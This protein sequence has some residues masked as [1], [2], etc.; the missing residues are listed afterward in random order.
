MISFS[1]SDSVPLGEISSSG[2][3]VG[4]RCRGG[5]GEN[6]SG[7]VGEIQYLYSGIGLRSSIARFDRLRRVSPSFSHSHCHSSLTESLNFWSVFV[8]SYDFLSFRC[9][10]RTLSRTHVLD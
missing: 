6:D 7:M 1:E 2:M 4:D 8:S 3:A 10:S 9:W 5:V